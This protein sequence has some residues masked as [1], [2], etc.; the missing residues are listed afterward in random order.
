M[1]KLV[2]LLVT[3]GFGFSAIIIILISVVVSSWLA[4]LWLF[5]FV[6][7]VKWLDKVSKEVE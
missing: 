6:I 3:L 7:F 2:E 4:F 1:R 5:W